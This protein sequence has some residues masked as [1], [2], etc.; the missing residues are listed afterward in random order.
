DEM[1]FGNERDY[2]NELQASGAYRGLS[3]LA[4]NL[5]YNFVES[6]NFYA[7]RAG[8]P[9][10]GRAL[11]IPDIGIGRLVEKPSDIW[12]YLNSYLTSGNNFTINAGRADRAA[13]VT[14]Y[15]YLTDNAER[16]ADTLDIDLLDNTLAGAAETAAPTARVKRLIDDSWDKS[17]LAGTWLP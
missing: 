9:W 5:F 17:L 6:D 15:S 10:R 2:H 7:D 8:T 12:H 13:L 16:I 11:Y 14:G 1:T 4:G 3:P